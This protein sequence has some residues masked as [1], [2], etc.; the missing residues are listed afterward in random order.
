MKLTFSP[1]PARPIKS[2]RTSRPYL[3]EAL[4]F[5]FAQDTFRRTNQP[6]FPDAKPESA[7]LDGFCLIRAGQVVTIDCAV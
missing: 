7:N 2:R 3:P 6:V 4:R 1:S 5:S